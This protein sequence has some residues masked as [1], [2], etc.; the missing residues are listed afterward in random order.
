MSLSSFRV[1]DDHFDPERHE[2]VGPGSQ[3]DSLGA[4]ATVSGQA[5]FPPDAL[6]EKPHHHYF[7]DVSVFA[8]API[9]SPLHAFLLESQ[10]AVEGKAARIVGLGLQLG[11]PDAL[12]F[13]LLDR[14]RPRK[15]RLL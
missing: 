7:I 15:T 12:R 2:K 8:G 13:H 11:A 5:W 10:L 9:G 3:N 1:A 14:A 4:P 6:V